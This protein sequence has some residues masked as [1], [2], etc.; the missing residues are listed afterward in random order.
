MFLSRPGSCRAAMLGVV[1]AVTACTDPVTIK[2]VDLR[3]AYETINRTALSGDTLSDTTRIVLR[4]NALLDAF[5][6][7]P[8]AVI[9]SLRSVAIAH[10]MPWNDLFALAELNYFRGR[11]TASK[12]YLLAAALYAYAVL[13]PADNASDRPNPYTSQFRQAANFYNLA[14][15]QVISR[16]D[17][18]GATLQGGHFALPFGAIDLA[19]DQGG[20]Q[21]DGR[22]FVSFIPTMNLQIHGFQN[23]YHTDGIGAPLAAGLAPVSGAS[24]QGGLQIP[25]NLR[26]P[27]AAVLELPDPR[28][29]LAGTNLRATLS[30]HSIYDTL[31]VTIAGQAVP[32]E[33]DQTAVRALQTSEGRSWKSELSGF[34]SGNLADNGNGTALYALEPHRKGRMPV[35]LVHGTASSPFRWADMVNDLLEDPR[36][37]EHYEFWFF[38]Y[39]TGNPI[40]FSALLLRHTLEQT[41]SS[42]GGVQAD[43]ALGRMV[44]IGHSQ[45]G[46]LAKMLTIETGD[47]VW[48]AFS[49]RPFAELKVSPA[50]RDLL[51]AALFLHPLPNV[52]TVIFIATPHRGSYLASFSVANLIGRFIALPLRITAITA[53]VL[54]ANP[55]ALRI[56]PAK[57]RFNA[58]TGM[59][60]NNPII[61][62]VATIP[63]APSIHAHSIIPV[64][65]NGPL[66]TRD[67]GVVKYSSAHLDGVDSELVVNSG[68][69][70]QANPVTIGEVRRI[71][72][73]QLA[74][75]ASHDAPALALGPAH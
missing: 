6:T 72:L 39:P 18:S 75:P 69:S 4:R 51:K 23:D 40:A 45:G 57:T 55:D 36:I 38:T 47:R 33:F 52:E 48:S 25:A 31:T 15:T 22:R 30:I 43:P 37:R 19:T 70:T 62:E 67:D 10:G 44:I 53:E 20:D 46:L 60:P 50:S 35:V 32:L 73:E 71:L 49:T 8:D 7:Q 61:R 64:Q 17:G 54:T 5:A 3:T 28:R 11:Q 13:F 26:V 1:L 59:S 21:V 29:Q 42:L 63:V 56:D 27:T 74:R 34:F 58:I 12:P 66:N 2:R 16:P 14:L 65:G 9:V 68:H 24:A 41:A